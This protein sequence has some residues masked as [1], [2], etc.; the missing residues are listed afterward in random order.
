MTAGPVVVVGASLAGATT[1]A[2]LRE[3]GVDREVVL[4]GQEDTLPYERP[5]LS[6]RYLTGELGVDELLV[7]PQA[8]YDEQG[9]TLRL[10]QTAVG[11]DP[12]RRLVLLD[13]GEQVP[14]G[15]VVLATGAAVVTPPIPG[16]DLAGV[17]QLRTLADADRLRDAAA[18]AG[19]VVVVGLGFLG[20][21]VAATL[22][23]LGHDV[24]A[25]DGAPG[26]LWG[27]LGAELSQVA[28]G[29]HERAGVRLVTG[30]GVA[31]FLPDADGTVGAVELA[32]G[33]RLP[34]DLVVVAVGVRP[35]SGWLTDSPLRLVN[36]AVE[37]DLDGRTDLPSVLAVGDLVATRDPDGGTTRRHEHWSSAIAQGRRAARHL[38]GLPPEP[39][40]APYFWSDEYDRILQYSGEP[41]VGSRLVVRGDLAGGDAPLT[42][43]WLADGVVTAVASVNDGRQF[44]RGQRL[45]GLAVD[46]AALGDPA[47]DLRRLDLEA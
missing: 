27:P 36:G 14:Y 41:L 3:L 6:K 47:V 24:T 44:R 5:E 19:P 28:R 35:S 39:P 32:T 30:T 38:A 8:F 33:E 26:P 23:G 2:T 4:L 43:F 10:G 11:L 18:S 9:I 7:H 15:A 13:S 17:H 21:E 45:L 40:A 1:A 42:V 16:I 25:V 37:V 20:S 46:P 12:D 31:A 29:W 22:R 34:A